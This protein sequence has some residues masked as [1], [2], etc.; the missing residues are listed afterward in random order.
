M[1]NLL[2]RLFIKK[3]ALP[4]GSSRKKIKHETVPPSERLIFGIIFAMVALA[5][6]IALEIVHIVFLKTWNN[7]IFAAITSITG[8]ILGVFISQKA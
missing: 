1:K 4:S 8:T 3:I 6:L 7:E 5:G 2:R